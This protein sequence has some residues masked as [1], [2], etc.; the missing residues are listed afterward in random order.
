MNTQTQNVSTLIENDNN[1]SY[2]LS[3]KACTC[4]ALSS[5]SPNP[6]CGCEYDQKD[7]KGNMFKWVSRGYEAIAELMATMLISSVKP[8]PV[9]V[10]E[11]LDITDDLADELVDFLSPIITAFRVNILLNHFGAPKLL[12]LWGECD[13]EAL[14]EP[15]GIGPKTVA[16]LVNLS[17]GGIARQMAF[18]HREV[19][20]TIGMRPTGE[21]ITPDFEFETEIGDGTIIRCQVETANRLKGKKAKLE[22]ELRKLKATQGTIFKRQ[23]TIRNRR[24]EI[25]RKTYTAAEHEQGVDDA[26]E[27][28]A[29]DQEWKANER[30]IPTIKPRIVAIFKSFK[31]INA[32]MKRVFA[33]FER[34]TLDEDD[35]DYD[36]LDE[37]EMACVRETYTETQLNTDGTEFISNPGRFPTSVDLRDNM[38]A[39]FTTSGDTDSEE[40]YYDRW[41]VDF[42]APTFYSTARPWRNQYECATRSADVWETLENH[43]NTLR[44]DWKTTSGGKREDIEIEAEATRYKMNKLTPSV[45]Y[46]QDIGDKRNALRIKWREV[47]AEGGYNAH[48]LSYYAVEGKKANDLLI[49]TWKKYWA[50]FF[51]MKRA[52]TA[53]AKRHIAGMKVKRGDKLFIGTSMMDHPDVK[54][55]YSRVYKDVMNGWMSNLQQARIV[56]TLCSYMKDK[57][58]SKS[59]EIALNTIT[60]WKKYKA[61]RREQEWAERVESCGGPAAP[62]K[63]EPP[64][65][66]ATPK[67]STSS[68]GDSSY[69][70][71]MDGPDPACAHS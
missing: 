38:S 29:L 6:T 39:H 50:R 71:Y 4:G 51:D 49:T 7:S 17:K 34:D 36:E 30:L 62:R 54:E 61:D 46:V 1:L 18:Q 25:A 33:G 45:P 57:Q 59:H 48:V 64:K 21:T 9:P 15:A 11:T 10:S 3:Y 40:E 67:R 47:K 35:P 65:Q 24:F 28:V 70:A 41:S 14:Q 43:L 20:E 60:R 69:P 66:K 8:A 23:H 2:H 42:E 26:Y 13:I 63:E 58:G 44:A 52:A 5:T 16:H 55:A 19:L 56:A 12:T 68:A 32:E 37:G 31:R 27:Y 22:Q 53:E